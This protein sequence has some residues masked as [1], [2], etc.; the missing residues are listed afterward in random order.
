MID[1]WDSSVLLIIERKPKV[2]I[3]F[4]IMDDVAIAET[5]GRA[6]FITPEEKIKREGMDIY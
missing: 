3:R 6:A 4:F 5:S 2:L 1:H